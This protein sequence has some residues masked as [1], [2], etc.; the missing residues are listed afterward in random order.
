MLEKS[1]RGTTALAGLAVVMTLPIAA[2]A[3]APQTLESI[4]VTATPLNGLTADDQPFSV[5]TFDTGDL[6]QGN[7]L[8]VADFLNEAGTSFTLN[9]IQNNPLQPDLQYRG[10][11]ASP[12]LGT[13]QGI[14]VYQNGVRLNDNFGQAVN[15]DLLPDT[16]LNGMTVAGGANPLMGLNSLGGAIALET[17]TGFN[18]P[19]GSASV[20]YGSFDRLQGSAT[21]G[22]NDGTFGYFLGVDHFREDGWRDFSDS[23]ATNL[24]GAASWRGDASTLDLYVNAGDTDL[25]GNGAIPLYLLETDR[26]A[27]FTHP[28][29]TENR[30]GMV[31]L[32][33]T[34]D[35]DNGLSLNSRLFVRSSRT[36]SFNGDGAEA[37]ACDAPYQ[38]YLCEDDD[39]GDDDDDDI[40]GPGDDDDLDIAADEDPAFLFDQSGNRVSSDYDGVNNRSLRKEKIWGGALEL[41]YQAATGGIDHDLV[42]GA[43]YQRGRTSFQSSV[44]F[45]TLDETRGTTGSGLYDAEGFTVMRSVTESFG[46]YAGD[47]LKLT[48]ALTASLGARYSHVRVDNEDLSGD[49]P[50]LTALA[51]YDRLNF[52]GGLTYDLSDS[53]EVYAG[54]HQSSRVPSPV[55]LACSHEDQPCTLPNSFVADPPLK[56][57]VSRGV[58]AGLRGRAGDAVRWS[59][60]IF[61]IV[62]NDDIIFQT[63]GG[64]TANVGFFANVG[65]TRRQ[66]FELSARGRWQML[67]WRL[68][69][70]YLDATFRDSFFVSSPNHPQ[71]EEG[72][73]PVT[74]GDHI[75]GLPKHTLGAGLQADVTQ[76][77]ML[78]TSMTLRSGQYFRGDEGNLLSK[79]G[80]YAIF[81]A[82]AR[83]RISPNVALRLKVENVFDTKYETF[84]TF[85]EPGEV[86]GEEAGDDPRFY[87]PGQPRGVWVG[88]DFTW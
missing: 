12:L 79:T 52:G 62:N 54:A 61:R 17:K 1:I 14:V 71:A 34:H 53:L 46:L 38:A 29:R 88:V 76:A 8:S 50:D 68:N 33:G 26:D 57:V 69:Y 60:D 36:R 15:W 83:Y 7:A 49:R 22:G 40:L 55:E 51:K 75:P 10:F 42:L 87:G 4:R 9:D 58:E 63:S 43:D 70:A 48:D 81:D 47:T 13:P 30:F 16:F 11:T 66:G 35:F 59:A 20:S 45:A 65:D 24:Y 77:L 74:P 32:A 25:K 28:D 31:T 80:G 78:G 41:G 44:E 67:R 18:A 23:E 85:G 82:Q 86:L 6:A 73:I 64:V 3:Q 37:E 39:G 27:V 84:G 21:L 2:A 5:Q 72:G 19:G 56:D